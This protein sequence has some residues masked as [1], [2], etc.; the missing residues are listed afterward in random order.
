MNDQ[1][2]DCRPMRK[3]KSEAID[4]VRKSDFDDY[5]TDKCVV[6][7]VVS[8]HRERSEE[9]HK[10]LVT[11]ANKGMGAIKE[12]HKHYGDLTEVVDNKRLGRVD[13][14]ED[15]PGPDVNFRIKK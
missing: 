6:R 4:P 12:L 9:D 13:N 1:D 2:E 8:Q 5:G 7:P 11:T 10:Q 14:L 3:N 15:V